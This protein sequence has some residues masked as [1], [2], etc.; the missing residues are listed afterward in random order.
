MDEIGEI[1][2][3]KGKEGIKWRILGRSKM[4]EIG[5]ICNG[6]DR[7]D[8]QITEIWRDT[9]AEKGERFCA[10]IGERYSCRG[11]GEILFASTPSTRI[12]SQSSELVTW[13]IFNLWNN[14]IRWVY[15]QCS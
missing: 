2:S 7:E 1:C 8:I 4:V 13:F 11:E 5:Q 3:S 14:Q 12:N 6:R 9:V 15:R 10:E